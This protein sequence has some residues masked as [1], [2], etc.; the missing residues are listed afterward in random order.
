[1]ELTKEQTD[2]IAVASQ[3]ETTMQ[4]KG[5]K[6]FKRVWDAMYLDTQGGIDSK[7]NFIS[8]A[9]PDLQKLE[10]FRFYLGYKQALSDLWKRGIKDIISTKNSILERMKEDEDSGIQPI[11]KMERPPQDIPHL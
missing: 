9:E 10:D 7:G 8:P 3:V 2:L 4:T 11:N 6:S 1:M 5:W